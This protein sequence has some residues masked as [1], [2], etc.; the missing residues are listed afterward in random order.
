[1][2]ISSLKY[3]QRLPPLSSSNVG[4]VLFSAQPGSVL[5]SS[6]SC[7][8]LSCQAQRQALSTEQSRTVQQSQVSPLNFPP[9]VKDLFVGKFNKS[10]LSYAEVL[11]DESQFN[12]ENKIREVRNFLDSN[13]ELLEQVDRTGKISP[14]I[15]NSFKQSGLFGLSI[16]QEFGGAGFLCTEIARFYEVF[17]CQLSLSEFMGTNEFL[18]YGVLLQHGSVEQKEKYLAR[19]AEGE[20]MASWC[21]AEGG[22]GSDPDSVVC[23]AVEE[24]EEFVIT[25]TK[26]WVTNGQGA[27]LFTVFAKLKVRNSLGEEEEK[28]TCFLVDKNE[29]GVGELEISQ[30][31]ALAGMRGL[32][33]CD[34][35]FEKCRVSRH[36]VL[37]SPGEGVSVLQ[38]VLHR[39]KYMQAAGVVG[40]LR[41]LL[42]DTI[43]HTK[44]RKQFGMPLSDFCLVRQ[45]LARMAAKLY[46]LE[47]MVF[48]TAGLADVSQHPDVEVESVIVKQF[49][50]ETSDYIVSGCLSL[51]GAQVNLDTSKY[52]QYMRD[53]QVLQG[54]QGSSNINKCF[55]GIS[56]LRHLVQHQPELADLRQPANGNI[57]KTM[58]YHCKTLEHHVDRVS[59]RLDLSGC[60]HPGLQASARRL[61]WCVHKVHFVAQELLL[62]RGANIQVEEHLLERLSDLVTEVFVMTCAISRASRSFTLGLDNSEFEM[63]M[64]V[65][66]SFESKQ[67]VKRLIWET[68]NWDQEHSN[69]DEYLEHSGEYITRRGGYVA[70]HPLTKNS[71]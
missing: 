25:G 17:G 31:Y 70:V 4:K 44:T 41:I 64:V 14:D 3:L 65:P 37:G 7:T 42:D 34:V 18:G 1:M 35:R 55:V 22:T 57:I 15:I 67:R 33:V 56:G 66:V 39:N 45:Q 50:A 58:R 23:E 32:E 59:L 51:L 30:P 20:M 24:G 28:L 27:Q 8:G 19:L 13:K 11:N 16:P 69:R 54:W 63:N 53:N 38:S 68:L 71:F 5:P 21:L 10:V 26:T 43:K 52:Q 62:K 60:V 49:A 12:L 48:L 36:A 40:S 9:F 47:S 61:E 6:L 46:C 29:L 2:S